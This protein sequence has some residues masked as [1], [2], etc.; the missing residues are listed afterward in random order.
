MT[1]PTNKPLRVAALG[2]DKQTQ[3]LLEMVFNGP[4]RGEYILVEQPDIA[5]ACIFDLDSMDASKL[6]TNYRVQ[7]PL[8]P[9]IILSLTLQD[10]AGNLFVK[11][12]IEIDKLL[13][14][15]NKVKQMKEEEVATGELPHLVV[16]S[17][18]GHLSSTQ[19]TRT[20][21]L[22]TEIT[23]EAEEEAFHQFCGY[24]ADINP[25][26]PEEVDKIYYEPANYLQGFF[27]KAYSI[28][29]QLDSGGI[30]VEGL[31]TPMILSAERNQLF[32]GCDST[33]NQL[34]T[35]TLLPLSKSSHLRMTTLSETEIQQRLTTDKLIAQPLDSFLWKMAL[36]TSRGK[37]PKGADLSRSIVLLHWPNFTRLI[38]TPHAME[39]SALWIAQP[40]S[41]LDTAKLLD[42]P[43]RYVF[44][45]FSAACAIKLAFIDRRQDKRTS[46]TLATT[47]PDHAKRGLFKRLLA[48]LLGQE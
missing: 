24:N 34:R 22:S 37:I 41:L 12:P 32:C 45:F 25:D 39:I 38:V 13:K 36:W 16:K 7:Y 23:M 29:L 14:S 3:K 1:Q 47:S 2:M 43:Q 31:Y 28:N 18:A 21:K 48:R 40:Q 10:V 46:E 9:T 15:L 5:E 6:W 30:L 27:E 26:R 8:L 35:M 44:S 42:I 17:Q 11:K 33:E 20:A 19:T 4:G